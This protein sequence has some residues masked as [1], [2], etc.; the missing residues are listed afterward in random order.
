[1]QYLDSRGV[2]IPF[3]FEK[4]SDF[5]IVVLKLVF[6]NC[7]RSYDEIAG[8]AKM[9]SRIL[10]EGVDDKFFKDLEFRAINLEASSGFES[11]EINLSCLKENFDFALKSLEKLLLKPRIEEK[12][13]QK[14]KINALGELASKNSDFDYLAKNLLN[15]Q[16]FKCKEFQSSNDGDEKSIEILSLKDLQNFYKNFIHLS[17]LVVIL[18]GDLEEKQAKEDLLKLLSKLQIGKKNTPKK[19]ELSKNIKDEILIR[20]ESEQAYIYFATPFFADFKDKDLYLAKIALFVLGQG[21]F[22]SRIMEEIRVKRGLAY[23][24]Y[25]M[26]D[27]NMSFSRVFGYLQTKNES[28]KEAKKIVKE[29]FEDFIKNGMTQNELD[30]AKNFLIGSTPLRYEG[31]SKRLSMAFN[32]FYQGLNLGYYKEELKLMEKVKLETINAYI[33]KHQELLNISFASIQNEN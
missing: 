28:A 20:P 11:L 19:Y 29:L 5:S 17:D 31:L 24:A 27:M 2:K 7:A 13:L 21:G 3:I 10:N 12:I 8:L 6:R 25:A 22:G 9:F 23:S 32:E 33:N 4:N 26:L 30:Q 14:L 1:M 18:G 16:I 15:A